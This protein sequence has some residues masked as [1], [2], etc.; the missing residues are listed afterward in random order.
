MATSFFNEKNRNIAPVLAE[1]ILE[2]NQ[3]LPDWL[4]ELSREARGGGRGL[5]GGRRGGASGNRFGG[6]DHRVQSGGASM[7]TANRSSGGGGFNS[8]PFGGFNNT[9]NTNNTNN[10]TSWGQRQ[11][12]SGPANNNCGGFVPSGGPRPAQTQAAS[13]V[14]KTSKISKNNFFEIFRTGGINKFVGR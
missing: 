10:G 1:L 4:Q 7:G 13:K 6:R 2:A 14:N 3:E 8:N 5:G 9:N 11:T 12:S